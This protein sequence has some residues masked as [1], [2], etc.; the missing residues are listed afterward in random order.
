[1]LDHFRTMLG[2][3]T[4]LS[5]S[6]T[7]TASQIRSAYRKLAFKHHPDRN[8]GDKASEDRFKEISA[9]YDV[10]SDPKRRERYDREQRRPFE[11]PGVGSRKPGNED[12]LA[13]WL[14]AANEDVLAAWL[15]AAQDALMRG[16]QIP[17]PPASWG[18]FDVR[19]FH[20]KKHKGVRVAGMAG[21]NVR[22]MP[23]FGG[24]DQFELWRKRK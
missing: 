16:I 23:T 10:L 6:E 17:S 1:M 22:V 12:V 8:P 15:R 13:A 21:M 18:F 19:G 14:R 3:Y 4:T 5:V 2:H 7:A 9:A 24:I 20:R 11:R